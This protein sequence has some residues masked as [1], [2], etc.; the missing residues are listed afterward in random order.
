MPVPASLVRRFIAA[1]LALLLGSSVAGQS[2]DSSKVS[3]RTRSAV[4]SGLADFHGQPFPDVVEAPPPAA[5]PDSDVATLPEFKVDTT[6][7]PPNR[8]FV[9]SQHRNVVERLLPGTG[10]NVTETRYG[11]RTVGRLFFVPVFFN[12]NW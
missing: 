11:R 10:V 12:L 8:I 2:P 1:A 7:L 6:R 3:S 4:L 5:M 9:Q